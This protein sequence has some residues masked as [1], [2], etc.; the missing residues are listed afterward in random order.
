MARTIVLEVLT[1]YKHDTT[2]RLARY[3]RHR[4]IAAH[5]LVFDSR[6]SPTVA[7]I[8]DA[9]IHGG[10]LQLFERRLKA[11]ERPSE[12]HRPHTLGFTDFAVPN[13]ELRREETS[14]PA[15]T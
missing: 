4:Q 8:K 3:L 2:V 10:A 7:V 15:F 5:A 13:G 6:K 12:P 14:L 1:M 11:L 9:E